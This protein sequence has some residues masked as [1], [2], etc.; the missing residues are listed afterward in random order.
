MAFK[1]KTYTVEIMQT[2]YIETSPEETPLCGVY[3]MFDI[4]IRDS[5]GNE[6][7]RLC[8]NDGNKGKMMGFWGAIDRIQFLTNST[9]TEAIFGIEMGHG[10]KASDVSSGVHRGG[11]GYAMYCVDDTGHVTNR[12]VDG[13]YYFVPRTQSMYVGFDTDRDTLNHTSVN[14]YDE[15]GKLC[16]AEYVWTGEKYILLKK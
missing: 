7:D 2:K 15:N 14:A 4:V 16:Q 13:G 9:E 11:V 6:T 3:G 8:L 10:A 1:D 5:A 12:P